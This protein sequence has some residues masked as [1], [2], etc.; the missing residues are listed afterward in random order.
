MS[1]LKI[2][3]DELNTEYIVLEEYLD[4]KILK[5]EFSIIFYYSGSNGDYYHDLGTVQRIIKELK[6]YRTSKNSKIYDEQIEIME[7]AEK[8]MTLYIRQKKLEKI[9]EI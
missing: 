9:L 8:K 4:H 1:Q 3:T 5:S 2:F 7:W 6:W